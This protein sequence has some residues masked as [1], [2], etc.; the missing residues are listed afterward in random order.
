MGCK[1]EGVYLCLACQNKLS[2]PEE[3]CPI[4]AK[5]SMLGQVHPNC[6]SSNIA[7]KAIMV[8]ADYEQES[9]RNLIWHLKYNY[10]KSIAQVLALI[11]TDHLVKRD[12]LNYFANAVVIPVPLHKKRLKLRGFNQADLIAE[13]FSKL[14]GLEYKP[15]LK[16][17]R[18]TK[19]QV[20]LEREQRFKNVEDAFSAIATPSLG[21]RKII[22]IDDVA[23]TGATLNECAKVLRNQEPSEIWGLV[24]ARN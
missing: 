13:N 6:A 16:R 23:T 12:L 19:S 4:C 5:P 11:L 18:N 24:A 2:N 21:E 22:L 15:I 10:V 7:L 20:D 14:T 1:T 8:A 9:V 17:A 3:H